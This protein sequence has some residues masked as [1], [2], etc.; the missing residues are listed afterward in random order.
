MIGFHTNRGDA[1][2]AD[3]FLVDLDQP[4]ESTLSQVASRAV[5][6]RNGTHFRYAAGLWIDE[7]RLRF[8]ASERNLQ[9]ITRLSITGSESQEE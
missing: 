2:R 3:L 1:E 9:A 8:L 4:V 6:L 7:G 5:S